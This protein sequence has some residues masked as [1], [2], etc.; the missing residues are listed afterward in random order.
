MKFVDIFI[1]VFIKKLMALLIE[2]LELFFN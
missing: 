2:P 1:D